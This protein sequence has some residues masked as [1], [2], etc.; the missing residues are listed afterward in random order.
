MSSFLPDSNCII[1]VLS[2]WH[3]HHTAARQELDRRLDRGEMM[4]VAAPAL[5]EAY[6]VLTRLPQ[7]RRLPPVQAL[8]ILDAGFV[9]GRRVEALEAAEYL[10]VLR[11]AATERIAGGRIYDAVIAA[12]A[13]AAGVDVLLTFNERHFAP[14]ADER[15]AVVVPRGE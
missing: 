12:C 8:E 13:R 10:S 9:A 15:L 14:F 1:A 7:P 11:R 6:S 2:R 5:V 3:E 4:V